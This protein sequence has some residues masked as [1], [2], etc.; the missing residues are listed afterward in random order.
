MFGGLLAFHRP[1][2]LVT[3][4]PKVVV[5]MKASAELWTSPPSPSSRKIAYMSVAAVEA[6]AA[7]AIDHYKAGDYAAAEAAFAEA[8]NHAERTGQTSTMSVLLSNRSAAR[9]KLD[10]PAAAA[11][12]ALLSLSL[13]PSEWRPRLRLSLAYE[14]LRQ[15]ADA[16]RE[17]ATVMTLPALPAKSAQEAAALLRRIAAMPQGPTDTVAVATDPQQTLRVHLCPP[18]PAVVRCGCWFTLAV[19]LS[20]EINLF[21]SECFA[22]AA[23]AQV[24]LEAIALG[25][26]QQQHRC[27]E[28][29]R[30]RIRQAAHVALPPG[31]VGAPL[32]AEGSPLIRLHRGRAVAEVCVEW[33]QTARRGLTSPGPLTSSGP[34]T[35]AGPADGA[36]PPLLVSLAAEIVASH[37]G[38]LSAAPFTDEAKDRDSNLASRG[39][40]LGLSDAAY[41]V[42]TL[43]ALSLPM[44][45]EVGEEVGGA[46]GPWT[47]DPGL[48]GG[49]EVGGAAGPWTLDPGDEGGE[50]VGG[51]AGAVREAMRPLLRNGANAVE[52]SVQG[53]RLISL[54]ATPTGATLRPPT[55]HPLIIAESSGGICGRV[56]DSGLWLCQWLGAAAR[57]QQEVA[58]P[59]SPSPSPSHGPLGGPISSLRVIELGSG[60]GVSGLALAALGAS[61]LL[62][63]WGDS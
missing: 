10:A 16:C 44:R 15:L 47:L 3:P 63:G 11:H 33:A 22:A 4:T 6:S 42:P 38:K 19:R 26:D 8:I 25:P 29:L 57:V 62:T 9:L 60:V 36:P 54:P 49:E 50:E 14:G 12:D 21:D 40:E 48:E 43:G 5:E 24:R 30:I 35:S 61:V 18:L 56:W 2:L 52:E 34:L 28:P 27:A 45:L 23:S 31:A 41:V 51:A 20:N 59:P 55:H 7:V 1:T 53:F 37:T 58:H 46:A 32:K 39:G 17:A 13:Q